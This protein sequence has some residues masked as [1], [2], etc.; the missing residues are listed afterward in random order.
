[1][2]RVR[3]GVIGAVVDFGECA[4]RREILRRGAQYLLQLLARFIEAAELEE[5]SAERDARRHVGGMALEARLTR[6]DGLLELP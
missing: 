6:G 4:D 2:T 3:V 5:G 1:M